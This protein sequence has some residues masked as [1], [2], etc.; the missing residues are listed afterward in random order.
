[1]FTW[2]WR[3]KLK[4]GSIVKQPRQPQEPFLGNLDVKEV[5]YFSI[6]KGLKSFSLDV[7]SGC[8]YQGKDLIKLHTEGKDFK[9]VKR[10]II[11]SDGG[12]TKTFLI[13]GYKDISLVISDNGNFEWEQN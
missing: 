5:A 8:F 12:S 6:R 10:S 11:H 2:K 4:D 7:K 9:A 13:F 1:M 3:A